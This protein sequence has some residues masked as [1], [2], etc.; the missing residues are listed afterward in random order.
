MSL[1]INSIRESNKFDC[2]IERYTLVIFNLD[3]R[4]RTLYYIFNFVFPCSL[5]AIMALLGFALPAESGEVGF[6]NLINLFDFY[7]NC[8]FRKWV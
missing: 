7:F 2:C 6:L 8:N 5:I 3:I 1:G 4:R